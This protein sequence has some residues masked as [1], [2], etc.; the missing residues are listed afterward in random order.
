M[1]NTLRRSLLCG[2]ALW[3]VLP[4][5]RAQTPDRMVRMGYLVW[6]APGSRGHLEQAL[7]DELRTGGY[8]EGRNLVVE[9][10][11][12]EVGGIEQVD[13]AA[14]ALGALKLDAI[15]STCT[16]STAAVKRATAISGVPVVMAV[17]SDPVS[18]GLIAS[19]RQP[20][21]N[22]TG[23][24][25]QVE[26]TLPK[27]M[28]YLVEALPSPV[29]A[30]AVL[31]NTG[32]PVHPRLWQLVE[33]SGATLGVGLLRVDIAGSR[34]L[35]RAFDTIAREHATA[36]LTLPDDNMSF[37]AR[38]QLVGLA[39]KQRMPSMF[40]AREFVEVGGLMSYGLNYASSYREA[41]HYVEKVVAGA[42]PASL[43]VSRPT[44]F[45]FVVNLATARELGLHLPQSLLLRADEVLR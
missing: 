38:R 19:Y 42:L 13:A 24:S 2:A 15:V 35:A 20:G 22:I 28:Q 30:V 37:N 43:P 32:N 44:R 9:R 8:T 45:E 40:G 18:Q 10:R 26:D 29:G 11:Y 27:M 1:R 3:S 16:P 33:R 39:Q 21:G 5:A 31:L 34:D 4:A 41:A 6:G 17:V 12:V 25:S 23:L 36:L 14:A 7:L